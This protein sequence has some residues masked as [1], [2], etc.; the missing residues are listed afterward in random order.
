MAREQCARSLPSALSQLRRHFRSFNSAHPINEDGF[1]KSRNTPSRSLL[2]TPFLSLV[3]S[4]LG[5]INSEHWVP[6]GSL[7]EALRNLGPFPDLPTVPQTSPDLP[8]ISPEPPRPQRHWQNDPQIVGKS[9]ETREKLEVL[10]G[11]VLFFSRWPG[12]G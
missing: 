1:E 5:A 3:I 7:G 10:V 12:S 4:F 11:H 9:N 8:R 2:L 6:V